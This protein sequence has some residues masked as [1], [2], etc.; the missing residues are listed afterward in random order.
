MVPAQSKWSKP[1]FAGD[2]SVIQFRK[3][4]P[5]HPQLLSSSEPSK[6]GRSPTIAR[7]TRTQIEGLV[8]VPIRA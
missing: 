7:A 1:Q 2:T 8:L 4:T 6:R 5:Q 3:L